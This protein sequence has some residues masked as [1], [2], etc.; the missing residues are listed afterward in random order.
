ME[1]R[2]I[3]FL[4]FE[5]PPKK[6]HIIIYS[7]IRIK[8]L[9]KFIR[10]SE[11]KYLQ[12]WKIRYPIRRGRVSGRRGNGNGAEKRRGEVRLDGV[13]YQRDV[14]EQEQMMRFCVIVWIKYIDWLWIFTTC[15]RG[16]NTSQKEGFL[17]SSKNRMSS[18]IPA[19]LFRSKKKLPCWPR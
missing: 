1:H 3:I 8:L 5:F 10:P 4:E 15:R 6:L 2:F 17:F 12:T 14:A 11:H 13:W 9:H 18:S 16:T 7:Q 19:P